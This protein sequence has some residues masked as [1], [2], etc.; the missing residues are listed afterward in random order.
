MEQ[1]ALEP[2]LCRAQ[3]AVAHKL[4]MATVTHQPVQQRW[5]LSMQANRCRV[6][7]AE[8][9]RH[10]ARET[11]PPAATALLPA[12]QQV[13]QAAPRAPAQQQNLC[14]QDLQQQQEQ[15]LLSQEIRQSQL[16]TAT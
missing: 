1:A 9:E 8:I 11:A 7:G 12:V 13:T 2:L 10:G 6:G 15:Q 5:S 3:L 4:G 16:L 14:Q